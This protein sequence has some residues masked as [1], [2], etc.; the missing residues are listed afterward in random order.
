MRSTR[1]PTT[2]I[3]LLH[4]IIDNPNHTWRAVCLLL[5]GATALAVVLLPALIVT[6][7]FGTT[8]VAAV[9]GMG[10]I[11]TALTIVARRQHLRRTAPTSTAGKPTA[12]VPGT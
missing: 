2:V 4:S 3:G 8:G 10:S 12:A 9:G 7:L 11:A 5:A 1:E 6:A